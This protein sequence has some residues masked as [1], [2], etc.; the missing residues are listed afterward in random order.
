[1][2]T[3][4]IQRAYYLCSQC[5]RGHSP[6][7]QQTRLTDHG[8]SLGVEQLVT[9]AGASGESF[10][11]AQQLLEKMASIWV[12]ESVIELLTEDLGALLKELLESGYTFGEKKDW[13]FHEDRQGHS[14]A[15]VSLD[16]TGVRQQQGQ[17]EAAEG[18]MP[19]VG[20]IYNP[21]PTETADPSS[22]DP[23][24]GECSKKK[25]SPHRPMEA[26]YV[27]GLYSLSEIGE[28][29]RLQAEQVGMER[30]EVWIGLTDGG[31]GLE[32]CLRS[33]FPRVEVIIL[34]YW[35]AA[36]YLWDLARTM[37]PNDEEA[38]QHLGLS[39]CRRLKEE[40]GSGMVRVLE[41]WEPPAVRH[42]EVQSKRSEVVNYFRNQQHRM[43]YPSYIRR[44]WQIGSGAVESACKTVVGARLK[45]AGMRW[46]EQGTDQ[47]CHVR[48]LYR[49][50][51]GQWD[52]FWKRKWTKTEHLFYHQK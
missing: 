27:S 28:R 42:K 36:E 18:R 4:R 10:E 40:G 9:L 46:S 47:M 2:G 19:Y 41:E 24:L 21:H 34:D 43:D 25:R 45:G 6:F 30:A 11:K 33:A 38:R 5:S 3:I 7:D 29:M 8:C 16:A 26:R 49:S 50:Q 37:Y 39:W 35:H 13:E 14:V 12:S 52:S 32:N 23:S 1:M 22:A 20:M 48:A 31:N 15:Y 17:G 51:K 44:G